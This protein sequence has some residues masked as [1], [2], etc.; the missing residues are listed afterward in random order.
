MIFV[1][2]VA[3]IHPSSRTV[4]F[5]VPF[6][7][8]VHMGIDRRVSTCN[9]DSHPI[10]SQ[11]VYVTYGLVQLTCSLVMKNISCT[12]LMIGSIA[13]QPC[14]QSQRVWFTGWIHHGRPAE[15]TAGKSMQTQQSKQLFTAASIPTH[16]GKVVFP[17][18]PTK[19]LTEKP[20]KK[21]NSIH[22]MKTERTQRI[23]QF[24]S[25]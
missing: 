10:P 18:N 8:S 12:C 24:L 13:F 11:T 20:V 9:A 5:A 14:S 19:N 22:S 21:G 25:L 15:V 16:W 3:G 2:R 4:S 23:N 1:H 7:H 6:L 17:Q